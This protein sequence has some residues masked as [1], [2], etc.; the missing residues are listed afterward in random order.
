MSQFLSLVIVENETSDYDVGNRGAEEFQKAL[1]SNSTLR[2][3][4]LGS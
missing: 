3:L 2:I 1:E 4:N